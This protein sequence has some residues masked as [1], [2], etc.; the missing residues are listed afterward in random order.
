MPKIF[1]GIYAYVH[2]KGANCNVYAFK[3]GSDIDL[4]DSGITKLGAVRGVWKQMRKDGIEPTNVRNIFHCHVH[5]DHVHADTFF[6]QNAVKNKGKVKIFYPKADAHRFHPNFNLTRSNFEEIKKTLP[7]FPLHNIRNTKFFME[8]FIDHY[9]KCETPENL[10][11]FEDQETFIIGQRKGKIYTTGGHTEGHSFI[12]IDDEDNILVNSDSGCLNEF[13]SDWRKSVESI[14]LGLKIN[15]DNVIG[16]H[17]PLKLG[18]ENAK[19]HFRGEY[20]RYD[21][22]IKPWLFRAKAGVPITISDC[23][24]R[25]VGFLWKLTPVNLWAHMS[26]YCNFKYFQQLDLGELSVDKN[27]VMFF[28]GSKDSDKFQFFESVRDSIRDRSTPKTICE[29]VLETFPY[30]V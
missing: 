19:K 1:D 6:Q 12:H 21:G 18:P 27:G 14:E 23:A 20:N 7:N 11:P 17:D 8:L 2:P 4:I 15:P 22:M 24:Y 3:D 13:T 25:R 30:D 26:V 9:V 29:R 28:T 5:P 10:Q 16:G